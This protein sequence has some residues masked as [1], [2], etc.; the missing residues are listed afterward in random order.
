M[1]IVTRQADIHD[2]D[3]IRDLSAQWGY[4]SSNQKICENLIEILDQQ[5]H[6]V[7][8]I[9]SGQKVI[10]WIHGM[11][12]RSVVLDPFIEIAG[13][14]IDQDFRRQ[15][16]GKILIEQIT[17]WSKFK[18]CNRIRVRTNTVRTE[19]QAFYISMGFTEI[20]EQKVYDISNS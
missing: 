15:G 6:L 2:L 3:S 1:Q 13:L 12:I 8:V 11:Y 14:V 5:D 16:M 20:K 4:A 7:L 19:A 9:L 18:N 10:G 17:V